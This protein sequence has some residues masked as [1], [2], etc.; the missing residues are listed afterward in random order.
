MLASIASSP[1]LIPISALLCLQ[2]LEVPQ[3]AV[4][5]YWFF[6][7]PLFLDTFL[8]FCKRGRKFVKKEL[9]QNEC[10]KFMKKNPG[11]M[12]CIEQR[13]HQQVYVPPGWLHSVFTVKPCVKMAYDYLN[14]FKF[15]TYMAAWLH[16]GRTLAKQSGQPNA[17]DYMDV[18]DVAINFAICP[19]KEVVGPKEGDLEKMPYS[20]RVNS[21]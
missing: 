20:A 7:N 10:K 19:P 15:P 4:L 2:G 1:T 21:V 17:N 3:G 5:A 13:A 18:S 11:A 14:V 12:V 9:T 8:R 16:V 6:V